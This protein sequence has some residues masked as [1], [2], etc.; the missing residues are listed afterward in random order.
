MFFYTKE[1]MFKIWC[2]L[3]I[4]HHSDQDRINLFRQL[5]ALP[6]SKAIEFD[7]EFHKTIDKRVDDNSHPLECSKVKI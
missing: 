7:K 3:F 6:A 2:R 5:C 4:N 1:T